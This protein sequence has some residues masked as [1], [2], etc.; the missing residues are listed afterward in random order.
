MKGAA[1]RM[2]VW[3]LMGVWGAGVMLAIAGVAET[4]D[5]ACTNAAAATHAEAGANAEAD[6]D[7]EAATNTEGGPAAASEPDEPAESYEETESSTVAGSLEALCNALTEHGIAFERD[8]V[9]AAALAG[10]VAAIDPRSRVLPKTQSDTEATNATLPHV[11]RWE[12]DVGYIDVPVITKP[13]T[14]A[15]VKHV[16]T[17]V[18]DDIHGVIIDLRDTGGDDFEA[19]DR[20]A[21]LVVPAGETLYTVRMATG[22]GDVAHAAKGKPVCDIPWVILTDAGTHDAAEVLAAVLKQQ[23]CAMIVGDLTPGDAAVR[24]PVALSH[25]WTVT[26]PVGTIDFGEGGEYAG[27]GVQ[28]DVPAGASWTIPAIDVSGSKGTNGRLLSGKARQDRQLMKRLEGDLVLRRAA[29][30]LLGLK[31]LETPDDQRD[32][33]GDSE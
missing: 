5:V 32:T 12:Q 24:R 30:I 9:A 31:A 23:Q 21:G 33:R 15:I 7:V 11:E 16:K 10:A 28:P 1:D 27:Q 22:K 3:V 4:N 14:A 17:W 2:K 29:D 19:V 18:V 26:L 6:G 13:I 20:I 25:E 8:R